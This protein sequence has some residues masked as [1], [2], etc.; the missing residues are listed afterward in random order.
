MK[1]RFLLTLLLGALAVLPLSA[2]DYNVADFGAKPDGVTLNSARIQAAIDFASANGGGRVV[3]TPGNWV[4][5]TIYVKDNVTLHLERGA[6]LLGSTN[7]WDYVKD[8][9]VGWTSMIFSIK[10]KNVGITG[11]G[12][13]DGRGFTTANHMV[14]YI[15]RGLFE[16]PLKLDRPN[17][18]NRPE[19]IYFRECDG[20][21]I[22][23]IFLKDP[24]SWNQTYDQCHN[25]LVERI[26][27]DSKSYWNNAGIGNAFI[28]G[29]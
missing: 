26:T 27:V 23:D 14:E 3:F 7:P 10:Q 13:I 5:G 4:T 21:T 6:T 24:G 25:V 15:H 29:K 20:V 8:P 9:Y 2:R 28:F 12:T 11:G 18:T 19:N 1:H 16:D 22:Q 17:E